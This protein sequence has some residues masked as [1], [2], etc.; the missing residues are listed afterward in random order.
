[1]RRAEK[2]TH[3]QALTTSPIL[4]NLRFGKRDRVRVSCLDVEEQAYDFT[5]TDV[6][7][8]LKQVADRLPKE[9][10]TPISKTPINVT[11]EG[12]PVH[13]SA[14][15]CDL[16]IVQVCSCELRQAGFARATVLLSALKRIL[17]TSR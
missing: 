10:G 6:E 15:V 17:R 4:L 16:Q 1:M 2:A 13:C 8:F 9:A 3:L 14:S 5:D 11:L 7:M 12:K